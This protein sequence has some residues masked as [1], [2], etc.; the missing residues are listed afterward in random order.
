[1][2]ETVQLFVHNE[3]EHHDRC[4]RLV[5]SLHLLHI[6]CLSK[7][8][9]E[10]IV[11]EDRGPVDSEPSSCHLDDADHNSEDSRENLGSS[12]PCLCLYLVSDSSFLYWL[13]VVQHGCFTTSSGVIAGHS[14]LRWND[15][16]HFHLNLHLMHLCTFQVSGLACLVF[17][18]VVVYC[19]STH[20]WLADR[21][22]CAVHGPL[23]SFLGQYSISYC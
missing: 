12:Y 11:R 9:L 21:E 13:S 10:I 19:F 23:P 18:V 4:R 8:R 17:V 15:A 1:M 14:N 5:R 16:L 2:P 6:G 3:S 22:Q 7:Y 20:D